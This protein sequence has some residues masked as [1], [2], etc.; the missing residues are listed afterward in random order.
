MSCHTSGHRG[1]CPFQPWKVCG[2]QGRW[3]IARDCSCKSWSSLLDAR[4]RVPNQRHLFCLVARTWSM[5]WGQTCQDGPVEVFA[6]TENQK[7]SKVV[8]KWEGEWFWFLRAPMRFHVPISMIL[9]LSRIA[10]VGQWISLAFL[11]AKQW[12]CDHLTGQPVLQEILNGAVR[13]T[14]RSAVGGSFSSCSLV[15]CCL[16]HLGEV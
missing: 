7:S 6:I 14:L 11:F 5:R 15:C 3:R 13:T 1:S 8:L 2:P 10:L 12:S 4:A 16:D 9:I